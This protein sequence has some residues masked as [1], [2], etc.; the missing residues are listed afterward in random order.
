MAS[1]KR[2]PKPAP[3]VTRR[4]A[5]GTKGKRLDPELEALARGDDPPRRKRERRL[6]DPRAIAL[7]PG[8]ANRDARTVYDAKVEA[9]RAASPEDRPALLAEAAWT[10]WYR[11]RSI[12]TLEA[13]AEDVLEIP[14][15][16]AKA[17][18]EEGAKAAGLPMDALRDP[19][20]AAWFRAV[21]ALEEEELVAEVRIVAGEKGAR[22]RVEVGPDPAQAL[23]SI[24]RRMTTLVRDHEPR[25]D[26][27]KPP[28]RRPE[29]KG[30]HRG[31][32]RRRGDRRPRSPKG[33]GKGR[34]RG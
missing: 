23:H 22:L 7:V 32:D 6:K 28:E 15:D 17:L 13:L 33:K 16:D 31:G 27:R 1:G 24:G 11:G 20:V 4:A 10:R 12:T 5:D 9:V 2:R 8:V 26:R 3:T 18:A 29:R 34:P 14:A 25:D 30:D 21:V 19:L